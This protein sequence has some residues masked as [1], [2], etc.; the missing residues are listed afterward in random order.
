MLSAYAATIDQRT[1]PTGSSNASNL[2]CAC[3]TQAAAT[4]VSDKD[5]QS[6]QESQRCSSAQLMHTFSTMLL[7]LAGTF[8]WLR[9]KCFSLTAAQLLMLL[10]KRSTES[11]LII[12]IPLSTLISEKNWGLW[13]EALQSPKVSASLT[14]SP[15]SQI[16]RRAST[17]PSLSL[18]R[19]SKHTSS[20]QI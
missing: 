13:N 17:V 14:K 6:I 11:A 5:C 16:L 2:S 4:F 9:I 15:S 12:R 8:A 18:S 1:G 7:C 10:Y 19:P 20:A 3:A